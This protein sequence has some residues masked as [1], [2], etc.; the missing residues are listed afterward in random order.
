VEPD[1]A[2]ISHCDEGLD[3]AAFTA[4]AAQEL[5]SLGAGM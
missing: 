3:V 5:S 2:M 1:E 4:R